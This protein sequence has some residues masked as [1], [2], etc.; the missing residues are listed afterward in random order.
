MKNPNSETG[1]L[2]D[3]IRSVQQLICVEGHYKTLIEK[4]SAELENGIINVDDPDELNKALKRLDD[5]QDELNDTADIRRK[6]MVYLSE[7]PKSDKTYWCQ[8]KHL[9][10][11]SYTAFE[12]WQGSDDDP[13]LY[14]IALET[15]KLFIKAQAHF[16]GMEI[17]DCAS[18]FSDMM[19][20]ERNDESK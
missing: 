15:N 14:Q 8:F 4:T 3:M 1:H 18:C 9:A 10:S 11:A 19:K 2:E 17:T 16:L 5:L 12:A 6:M 13:F 7:N 20:G